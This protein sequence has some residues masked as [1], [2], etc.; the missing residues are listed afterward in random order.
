MEPSLDTGDCRLEAFG[1][2]AVAVEPGKTAFDDP[3]AREDLETDSVGHATHDLDRPVAEF[4]K[5]I[6]QFV[7][8][9]GGVGEEM[10]QPIVNGGNDQRSAVAVLHIGWVRQ[11]R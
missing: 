7:A 1:E 4:G 11:R 8:P 2:T 9:I 5:G 10:S 6:E 3:A